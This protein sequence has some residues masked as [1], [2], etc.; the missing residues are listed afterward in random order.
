MA[1]LNFP[2]NP[3][4][5]TPVN[6]FSPTSTPDATTNGATYIWNGTAWAGS[7]DGTAYLSLEV[8][9]GAQ[10]VQSTGLTTFAG[11]VETA[12]TTAADA[13][14]TV[15]TKDY[16]EGSGSGGDGPIGYWVRGS[17]S[18]YPVNTADAL[19]VGGSL[20]GSPSIELN[21]G[22]FGK[23]TSELTVDGDA[24]DTLVTK[25]YVDAGTGTDVK[26]V[27]VAG[28]N[29]TGNLTIASTKVILRTTG[30]C[31]FAGGLVTVGATGNLDITGAVDVTGDVD[32]TGAIDIVGPLTGS[33][34]AN[35][36]GTVTSGGDFNS[37]SDVRVKENIKP[38]ENSLE[39]VNQLRGVEY[40]RT[41]VRCH[42]IGVIAQEIEKVYPEFVSEDS[43]GMKSVSYGQ[44]TAVLIEAVKELSQEVDKL[45]AVINN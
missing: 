43:E 17:G 26:Y 1:A 30:A 31:D 45:K 16:L 8:D 15:V 32:V 23:I 37:T 5:Q 25:S 24:S 36:T 27:E 44:M 40:D 39:K 20:P 2:N 11:K 14:K 35:F 12:S 28:D 29:M 21:V 3:G 13:D 42:Q 22:G 7:T 18:L 6:T 19:I 4:S 41:D 10:T 33:S 9:A 38:L 34:T